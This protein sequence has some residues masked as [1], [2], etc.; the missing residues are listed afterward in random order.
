MCVCVCVSSVLAG[1]AGFVLFCFFFFRIKF[2]LLSLQKKNGMQSKGGM[3]MFVCLHV[4]ETVEIYVS[5]SVYTDMCMYA[6]HDCYSFYFFE[7]FHFFRMDVFMFNA[8]VTLN[9]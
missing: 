6:V 5:E 2:Q 7:L 1:G 9:C 4:C 8:A 3:C